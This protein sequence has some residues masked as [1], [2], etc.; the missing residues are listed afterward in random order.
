LSQSA[1]PAVF[2]ATHNARYQMHTDWE[3]TMDSSLEQWRRDVNRSVRDFAAAAASLDEETLQAFVNTMLREVGEAL[4]ID[5]CALVE[6]TERPSEA[7]TYC[8]SLNS[9]EGGEHAFDTPAFAAMVEGFAFERHPLTLHS[10]ADE[11]DETAVAEMRSFLRQGGVGAALFVPLAAA[12]RTVG[13]WVF[14]VG[15]DGHVWREPVIEHLQML[16]DVV[17][18]ALQ[19]RRRE[20][21]EAV[22]VAPA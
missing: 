14:G 18:G 13:W 11:G 7:S 20:S 2:C 6:V 1:R 3:R 16:A 8:W 10:A 17:S 21:R 9:A 19:S 5:C 22:P 12:R 15:T 4:T